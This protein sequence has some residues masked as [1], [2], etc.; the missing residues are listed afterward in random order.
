VTGATYEVNHDGSGLIT[1]PAAQP[2]LATSYY[3]GD[4]LGSAQL[5]TSENGY[6]TWSSTYLPFG[7]EWNP[8]ITVNHYKFTGKERDSE[9]GL[10]NF[11]ARYYSSQFG[12]FLTPD[13]AGASATCLLNPQTQDRYAYVT[14]NPVN[15]TDP[16]GLFGTT[17]GGGGDF[18]GPPP[19]DFPFPFFPVGGGEGGAPA[20]P[21]PHPVFGGPSFNL[22]NLLSMWKLP[23]QCGGNS[24]C[25]RCQMDCVKDTGKEGLACVLLSFGDPAAAALCLAAVEIIDFQCEMRCTR[26]FPPQ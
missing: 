10:D 22:Q 2:A 4:R 7:Q 26:E 17:G 6:P 20:P 3:H 9:S 14:N 11:G 8:A 19:I 13:P 18:P 1:Y 23:G 5:T 25:R 15:R 16:T 12:R 24:E 21:T